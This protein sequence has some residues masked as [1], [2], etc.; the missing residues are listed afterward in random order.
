MAEQVAR[1]TQ[2]GIHRKISPPSLISVWAWEFF[3]NPNADVVSVGQASLDF[4][5]TLGDYSCPQCGRTPKWRGI[6]KLPKGASSHTVDSRRHKTRTPS[7]QP[8]RVRRAIKAGSLG[9]LGLFMSFSLCAGFLTPVWFYICP[10]W[11]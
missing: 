10:W 6:W 9:R 7:G 8:R 11:L 3:L 2:G 4:S 5:A 1:Q